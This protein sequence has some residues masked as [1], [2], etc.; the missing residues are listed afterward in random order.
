M[1]VDFASGCN[2]STLY[3]NL[4]VWFKDIA[5]LGLYRDLI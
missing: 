5:K 3:I 2:E 1:E 4:K